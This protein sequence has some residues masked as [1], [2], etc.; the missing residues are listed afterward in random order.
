MKKYLIFDFLHSDRQAISEQSTLFFK[1]EF[2][3]S[4]S[5]R[6]YT[7]EEI[8]NWILNHDKRRQFFISKFFNEPHKISDFRGLKKPFTP[9]RG[10]PGDIDIL[11]FDLLRP[12]KSI[13]FECKRVKVQAI[14]EG[15]SKINGAQNIR[16]GIIQ[17]NKYLELGFSKVF[18][19]IYLLH[20]GRQLKTPSTLHRIGK[21]DSVERLYNIPL[22]EGLKDEVGLVFFEIYQNTDKLIDHKY[23]VGICVDKEAKETEQHTTTTEKLIL[24]IKS[25][26]NKMLLQ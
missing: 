11:L 6:D 1:E 17:V 21:G 4:K 7:E 20:D 8:T 2:D 10:K 3:K 25:A 9:D 14:N 15:E 26:A 24:E 16:Q 19:V 22:N 23:G 18:L 12:N 5:V 13:A